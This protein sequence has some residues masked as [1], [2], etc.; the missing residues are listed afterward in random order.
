[1][2]RGSRRSPTPFRRTDY[3]LGVDPPVGERIALGLALVDAMLANL[4][5]AA[6]L[7]QPRSNRGSRYPELREPLPNVEV[8]SSDRLRIEGGCSVGGASDTTSR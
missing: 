1:V 2:P 5:N 6:W 7:T 3:L 4:A 8:A